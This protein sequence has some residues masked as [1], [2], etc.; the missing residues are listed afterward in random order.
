MEQV[1]QAQSISE[2][3]FCAGTITY[4]TIIG[5]IEKMGSER[6]YKF[7]AQGSSSITGS[8]SKNSSGETIVLE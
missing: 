8:S 7:F 4:K 1:L 2:I 6:L 5:S 3:I